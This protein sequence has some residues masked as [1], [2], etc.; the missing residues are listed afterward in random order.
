[1]KTFGEILKQIM[2]ERHENTLTLSKKLG[3]SHT[4]ISLLK[5]GKR[6]PGVDTLI[7]LSSVLKTPIE[8]FLATIQEGE[9]KV[10]LKVPFISEIPRKL[11]VLF[12]QDLNEW[13]KITDV[14]Y[15]KMVAKKF[16][17]GISKDK[18]AFYIQAKDA[19]FGHDI[20]EGD[21]LLIEPLKKYKDGDLVLLLCDLESTIG[22][23]Y[24]V[25]N[26]LAFAPL[27]TKE[28][29]PIN[30]PISELTTGKKAVYRVS[31]KI[32]VKEY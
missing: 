20:Q 9:E 22:R 5:S 11:P 32:T 1:M 28:H 10:E 2:K 8:I 14:D 31:K 19:E 6:K 4:F 13:E 15:P 16:E 23:I 27:E 26:V 7:A 29:Y 24:F 21:L 3:V 18:D 12:E 17:Y 25:R 30:I